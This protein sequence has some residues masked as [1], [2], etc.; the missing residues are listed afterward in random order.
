M[1][2]YILLICLL[3]TYFVSTKKPTLLSW[4][5][6]LPETI[7]DDGGGKCDDGCRDCIHSINVRFRCFKYCSMQSRNAP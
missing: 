1:K 4:D 3:S 6:Y 2:L 5:P 7:R